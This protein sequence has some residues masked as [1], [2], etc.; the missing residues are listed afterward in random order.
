LNE[1]DWKDFMPSRSSRSEFVRRV[2]TAIVPAV[3]LLACAGSASAS[4]S[5]ESLLQDDRL[6][7]SPDPA[8]QQEAFNTADDIGVDVVHSLVLWATLAPGRESSTKPANFDGSDPKSYTPEAWDRYDRLV[9][10]ADE[11]NIDLLL[12]PAGPT[13]LWANGCKPPRN[14]SQANCEPDP[15][16]YQDFFEAVSKRYSGKYT[17]ENGVPGGR[18]PKVDRYSLWNEPNELGWIQPNKSGTNAK[19]Y[20]DL[21]YAGIAGLKKGNRRADVLLGETAPLH[22]SL[23]FWQYVLCSDADGKALKGG[24]AKRAGCSSKKIKR[25]DVDG[26]AHHPY[27]RGGSP[28]FKKPKKNDVNLT[29]I[30]KLEELLDGAAKRKAIKRNAPIY[31]TEFGVS[32][33][34]ETT[35]FGS[36]YKVVAESINRAEYLGYTNKRVRSYAQYQL[37][38][39]TGL[40]GANGRG[41][42]QTGLRTHKNGQVVEK[43]DVFDAY[44]M[45]L[46]V[47]GTASSAEVWGGVRNARRK[48]VAIQVGKG[49]SFKTVK[50]VT[51]SKAGYIK[52]RGIKVPRGQSVRLLIE[53]NGEEQTSRTASLRKK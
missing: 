49:N 48:R 47:V 23:L 27:D 28:P 38:N 32:S 51:T 42:F 9:K 37:D 14:T 1:P 52:A 20:R 50:S 39:D 15:D 29:G 24:T 43:D 5:Q 25:L 17:D 10:M 41:I 11:K 53:V 34:P 36:S 7:A 6:F 31:F 46:Y 33:K 30:E 8:I 2:T 22:N 35:K 3:A 18:L 19:I 44:R 16:E 12:S 45:P 26:V 4:T 21:A 40:Q 13:P